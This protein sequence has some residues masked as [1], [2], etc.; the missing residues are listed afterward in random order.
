MW[1]ADGGLLGIHARAVVPV[2]DGMPKAIGHRMRGRA[3]L[4]NR[5]A[6]EGLQGRG[7]SQVAFCEGI[8]DFWALAG[9]AAEAR[10]E[11]QVLGGVSGSFPGVMELPWTQ[12]AKVWIA[13]HADEAGDRYA[14][15]IVEGLRGTGARAAR[16]RMGGSDGRS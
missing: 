5:A 3:W 16:A 10:P 12:D 14:R 1:G 4:A 2:K 9:W 8:A 11:M 6:L 7:L 15:Q 13:V